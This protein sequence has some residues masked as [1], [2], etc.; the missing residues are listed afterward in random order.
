[1]KK[2]IIISESLKLLIALFLFSGLILVGCQET[3]PDPLPPTT[4][5]TNPGSSTST[6]G[7]STTATTPGSSTTATTPGSSTTATTPGVVVTSLTATV[8][9][10][11][12]LT[13]LA[14]AI[15][16][17]GL[18]ADLSQG[19]LT[20]FAPSDD[21]FRAA[22]FANVAAINAA[23]PA[24]L[25]RILQYHVIGS[26][27]DK[28]A[29]P[30]A[31]NTSY[32]TLLPNARVVVY[33]TQAGVVSV[34]NAQITQPDIPATNAAIHI[35]NRVL[36][37]PTVTVVDLAKG[38]QELSFLVAAIERAGVQNTLTS[39]PENGF[40]VFAPTN[41]A[42]RAAGYADEAAIRA[43]DPKALAD[44]LNYHVLTTRAF[45][46]TLPNGAELVTAQGGSIRITNADGKVS[47]LGKG[48]GTNAANVTQADQV[49]TN[50]V[51]HV[52]DRVLLPK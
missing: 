41:A 25:K 9:G 29:F 14:A 19:L 12:N 28:S 48:N 13:F 32:Q 40:T 38:N 17:A 49:T 8:N 43:A 27:I 51:V 22:G 35:I 21:A 5:T 37:P 11:A 26:R 1:M 7:S 42:F 4:G 20:V 10:N 23:Q 2:T 31:V 3:T 18:G 34:N 36:M 50:G 52:I 6:P 44:V 46:Q 39:N 33:K 47:I 45:A 24:D 15:N 30:T 16:R